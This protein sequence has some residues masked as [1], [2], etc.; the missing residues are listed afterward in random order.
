MINLNCLSSLYNKTI[1]FLLALSL[2][3]ATFS[4][5]ADDKIKQEF[6]ALYKSTSICEYYNSMTKFSYGIISKVLK[7][8]NINFAYTSKKTEN[9]KDKK[10]SKKNNR[11]DFVQSNNESDL[12]IFKSMNL[13]YGSIFFSGNNFK[14]HS[15]DNTVFINN[16]IVLLFIFFGFCCLARGNIDNDIKFYNKIIKYCLV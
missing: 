8:S 5:A 7:S 9:S 1:S 2:L 10:Q 3:A 4:F 12:K 6:S 13:L 15:S 11:F 14:F 16:I